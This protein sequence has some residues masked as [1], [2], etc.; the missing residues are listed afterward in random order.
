MI[1][2]MVA[3]LKQSPELLN[4]VLQNRVSL[5]GISAVEQRALVDV[6]KSETLSEKKVSNNYWLSY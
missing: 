6:L 2:K 3:Q 1:K 5:V 4:L